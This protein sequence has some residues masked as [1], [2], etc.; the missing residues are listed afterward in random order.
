MP[1]VCVCVRVRVRASANACVCEC[2]NVR[3]RASQCTSACVSVCGCVSVCANMCHDGAERNTALFWQCAL[4]GAPTSVGQTEPA[5]FQPSVVPFK[6]IVQ[7]FV[8]TVNSTQTPC[9]PKKK[10]VFVNLMSVRRVS[11]SPFWN[12]LN[13]VSFCFLGMNPPRWPRWRNILGNNNSSFQPSTV[14]TSF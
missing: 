11:Q 5:S 13:R 4:R 6:R 8:T 7:A 3:M 10:V 12:C 9:S 14:L 2:A 1:S